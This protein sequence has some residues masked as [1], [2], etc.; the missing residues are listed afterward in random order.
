MDTNWY[1]YT[2]MNECG[3]SANK[4]A[5]TTH[6]DDSEL[7]A[8]LSNGRIYMH[9]CQ[10]QMLSYDRWLGLTYECQSFLCC[11]LFIVQVL[12]PE[13]EEVGRNWL[14]TRYVSLWWNRFVYPTIL[15]DELD[16]PC[17]RTP[18]AH[19]QGARHSISC[20]VYIH[21]ERSL[22]SHT[23]MRSF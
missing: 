14:R 13:K 11:C 4:H 1:N 18:C 5:C 3:R 6:R 8:Y 17:M 20:Q 12:L 10:P 21:E 7:S 22:S 9:I 2:H 19:T 23:L 15:P 16:R